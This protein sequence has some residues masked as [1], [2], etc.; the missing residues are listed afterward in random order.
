MSMTDP[1]ADLLT[2]IRNATIADKATTM[3]PYSKLK[4]EILKVLKDRNF[5]KDFLV[6]DAPVGKTIM[7]VMAYGTDGEQRITEIRRVSRPGRR[8]YKKA[9]EIRKVLGG[10]GLAVYSTP[11]GVL[12]DNDCRK[13]RIGG[14]IICTVW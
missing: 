10:V 5:V 7:I 13:R 12:S 4:I 1:I 6:E 8:I 2:R 14:E 9:T 3:V 11:Q